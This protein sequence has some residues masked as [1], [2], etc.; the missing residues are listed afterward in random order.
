MRVLTTLNHYNKNF[1]KRRSEFLPPIDLFSR[2]KSCYSGTSKDQMDQP[3]V[4][5]VT[6]TL[7][8]PTPPQETA[9]AS[10]AESTA[11][12][13]APAE[14]AAATPSDEVFTLSPQL[15]NYGVIAVLFL[16]VG[17]AIGALLF[18]GGSGIDEATLRIALRE[19]LADLELNASAAAVD[20]MADDDP[21]QGPADAPVTIVEFSDF[22]CSF[23]RRHYQQTL[24]PLLEEYD[25]LVKYVYRDYPG[26]G[27]QYAVQAALAAECANDQGQFWPYHN[28][29]FDNAEALASDDL[30]NMLVGFA[31]QLSLDVDAFS[32]CLEEQ[33]HLQD[34]VLDRTD[35]D[36]NGVSGTPGFF[37]N[38]R[39]LSGAQPIDTFRALIDRE[40]ARL[41]IDPDAPRESSSSS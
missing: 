4:P 32:A 24:A 14:P 33:T 11:A 31:G 37:I 13:I 29:L 7:H 36:S 20:Y 26:V 1:M 18:G 2:V 17:I 30:A 3:K 35:G 27:G 16:I 9:P 28:V 41:N 21:F 12:Y 10:P 23:C 15:F 38:G 34:I 6:D 39:F 40:L 25:G 22:L 5:S 19:E 8:D